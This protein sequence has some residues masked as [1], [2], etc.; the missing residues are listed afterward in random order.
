MNLQVPYNA[1]KFI[2]AEHLLASEGLSS[3]GLVT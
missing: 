1:G 2:D 3:M